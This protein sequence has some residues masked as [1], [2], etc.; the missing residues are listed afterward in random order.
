MTYIFCTEGPSTCEFFTSTRKLLELSVFLFHLQ[1]TQ[2][3]E[4]S[5]VVVSWPLP[6]YLS[7]NP[8]VLSYPTWVESCHHLLGK[9]TFDVYF[10]PFA[11]PYF[12]ICYVMYIGVPFAIDAWEFS[13][14]VRS[15]WD[16][17]GSWAWAVLLCW[18][19]LIWLGEKK[20]VLWCFC[21]ALV[22]KRSHLYDGRE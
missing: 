15:Q 5:F 4:G 13:L 2:R 20:H 17:S 19:A 10:L 18:Q 22:Y 12:N 11:P 21:T 1:S 14:G 3:A 7:L 8:S 16:W 9:Y 6:S